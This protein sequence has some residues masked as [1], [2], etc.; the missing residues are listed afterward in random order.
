MNR[1][2]YPITLNNESFILDTKGN[3]SGSQRHTTYSSIYDAYSNPSRYKVEIWEEWYDWYDKNGGW[4][5]IESRNCMQFTIG[6]YVYDENNT[7][8]YCYIT[9]STNRCWKVAS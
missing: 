3:V 2:Y 9:K 4:C 7:Q 5:W 1:R 8:Y 6:G